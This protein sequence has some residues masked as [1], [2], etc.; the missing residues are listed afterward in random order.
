[1]DSFSTRH[2]QP[3]P[4]V[5]I[6]ECIGTGRREC[7]AQFLAS[8]LRG[9]FQEKKSIDAQNYNKKEDDPGWVFTFAAR[10]YHSGAPHLAGLYNLDRSE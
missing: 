3:P 5:T 2:A 9:V 8:S 4:G 1:M 7:S 6:T 10:C